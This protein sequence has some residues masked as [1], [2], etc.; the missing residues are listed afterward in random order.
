MPGRLDG[1]GATAAEVVA[2]LRATSTTPPAPL[3]AHQAAEVAE[4]NERIERYGQRGSGA[5]VARGRHK[6]RAAPAAHRRAAH[7]ARARWPVAYRDELAVA[8]DPTRP[9]RAIEAIQEASE[10]LDR[11]PNEE[12][13]S[14]IDLSLRLRTADLTQVGWQ[15][16][17]SA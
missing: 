1:T 4:L 8:A 3:Q 14:S 15:R 6:R 9:L 10:L 5:K 17:R 13:L 7:G 2:E 16:R 12:L 11:N